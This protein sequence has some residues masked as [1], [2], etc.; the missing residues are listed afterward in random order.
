MA[1]SLARIRPVDLA[2]I[3]GYPGAGR[4]ATGGKLGISIIVS[5]RLFPGR[6]SGRHPFRAFSLQEAAMRHRPW[7]LLIVCGLIWAAFPGAYIQA[8]DDLSGPMPE[9]GLFPTGP[10]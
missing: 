6:F 1:L 7:Q 4:I 3:A 10:G 2:N 9:R 8:Q 5:R